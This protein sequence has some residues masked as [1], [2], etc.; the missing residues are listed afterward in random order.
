MIIIKVE[1]VSPHGL[2]NVIYNEEVIVKLLL[3][4]FPGARLSLLLSFS[5]FAQVS[6]EDSII[7]NSFG[8]EIHGC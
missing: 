8:R 3:V 6:L 1:C 7:I 4:W 5:I 2:I